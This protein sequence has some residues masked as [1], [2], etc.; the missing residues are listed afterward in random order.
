MSIRMVP[1]LLFAAAAAFAQTST[2]SIS[3]TL[4]DAS[5]QVVPGA[6]ITV[7]SQRTGETRTATSSDVGDFV[8]AALVPGQYTLK[9][10]AQGFRPLEQTNVTVTPSARL[11][12][13]TIQLE[14]G[15]V[16]ESIVVQSQGATVQTG[17]SENGALLDSKQLSMVSIRG[18][19]PVSMLRIL[20]G[21]TQGFDN[22]F[23]GGFYGTNVPN[24]Q[25]L[26]NSTTT[27]MS[28]GVN[29]GDGGAGGVFSATVNLDAVQEVK[30]QLSNYTAEY[31]RAGG[32]LINIIT[33]GGSR[34]YHGTG[35]WYKRHEMFNANASSGT[36]MASPSRSIVL[37][38]SEE[39]SAAR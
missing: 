21:V 12:L 4:A 1:S 17:N 30:V 28:D 20:P 11:A 23:A 3:G 37:K 9:V 8:F 29:G 36:A 32:A 16:T 39:P 19:D 14:V 38:R 26:N 33:K 15:T 10:K 25:G 35:Y 5:G 18:R 31:G 7:S 2:G 34:E 6:E 24:F 13:G 27:I 22:E